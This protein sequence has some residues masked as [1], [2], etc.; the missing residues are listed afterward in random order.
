VRHDAAAAGLAAPSSD[1]I[2]FVQADPQ[3]VAIAAQRLAA[4]GMGY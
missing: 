2:A 1:Q 4:A 3:D